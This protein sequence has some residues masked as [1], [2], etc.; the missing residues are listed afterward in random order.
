MIKSAYFNS[1]T[2][3]SFVDHIRIYKTTKIKID[4]SASKWD[5]SLSELIVIVDDCGMMLEDR[6]DH[7][8]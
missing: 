3:K 4:K 6:I 5:V 7:S 8:S 2:D 1:E